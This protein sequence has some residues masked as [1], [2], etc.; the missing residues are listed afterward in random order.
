MVKGKRVW[1][2]CVYSTDIC[3]GCLGSLN[4][5]DIAFPYYSAT[6]SRRIA[7]PPVLNKVKSVA[8][9]S[10]TEYL[11]DGAET[12]PAVEALQPTG[13]GESRQGLDR[14]MRS[15]KASILAI[16]TLRMRPAGAGSRSSAVDRT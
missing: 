14:G 11:S 7:S 4:I 5:F 13:V 8:V 1:C 9:P 10:V 2:G 6:W 3:G 16:G 12:V 15:C